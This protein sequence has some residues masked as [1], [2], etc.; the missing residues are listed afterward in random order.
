MQ[1]QRIQRAPLVYPSFS[2]PSYCPPSLLTLCPVQQLPR[3]PPPSVWSRIYDIHILTSRCFIPSPPPQYLS[4]LLKGK[5]SCGILDSAVSCHISL[6][7]SMFF[8]IFAFWHWPVP[9][10]GCSYSSVSIR[11]LRVRFALFSWVL[12]RRPYTC[13]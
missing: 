2:F 13:K 10:H 8:C 9:T 1:V 7:A 4:A 11:Y 3:H 5:N 12:D 6:Y